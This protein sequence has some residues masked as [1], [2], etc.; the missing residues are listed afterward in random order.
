[1]PRGIPVLT[2]AIGKAGAVNAAIAAVQMLAL[3]DESF[4]QKLADFRK[5]QTEEVLSAQFPD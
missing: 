4:A 1:M 5:A 2:V 3:S